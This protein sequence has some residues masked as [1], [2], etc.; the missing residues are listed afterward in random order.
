MGDRLTVEVTCV[1]DARAEMRTRYGRHGIY[2]VTVRRGDDVVADYRIRAPLN[3]PGLRSR[4]NSG[5][6]VL[7]QKIAGCFATSR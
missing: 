7:T 6:A 2:D 4:K 3:S 5:S 1:L